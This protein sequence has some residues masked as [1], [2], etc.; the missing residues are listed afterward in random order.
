MSDHLN[1]HQPSLQNHPYHLVDP[2]PWPLASSMSVLVLAIGAVLMMHHIDYWVFILGFIL[3]GGCFFGWWRD[4]L[5]EANKNMN[6]L[7]S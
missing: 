6:K 1:Q 5:K 7:K 2:S 3:I 4:V